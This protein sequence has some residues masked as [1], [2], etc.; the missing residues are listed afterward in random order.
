MKKEIKK[1]SFVTI[2]IYM[3][4]ALSLVHCTFLLLGLFNV[5]TPA[6]LERE[7]FNYVV[8]FVLLIV[9]IGLYVLFMFV[10][11]KKN[12]ATPVWFKI[13]LYVGLYVFINVYYYLGLYEHIAGIIVAYVFLAVVLNIFALAIFFNTQKSESGMIKASNTYTCF[14]VFAIATCFATIFEVFAST[15]KIL[16]IKESTFASLS[17]FVLDLCIVILVSLV[18][19]VMF[20][21]SLAK[22]K[23]LINGCL[24]KV[25]PSNTVSKQVSTKTK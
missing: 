4:L 16:L 7:H 14:S 1:T 15:L 17:M 9:L 25:Y 12:L 6:C 19:A 23:R 10:E 11:N 8:A 18:F 20:C 5:L 13:L 2:L 3:L 22:S 24:I 21:I